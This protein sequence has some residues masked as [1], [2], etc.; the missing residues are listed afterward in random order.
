VHAGHADQGGLAGLVELVQVRLMLE[1]VGVQTLLGDLHVGLHVVGEHLD[2]KGH[3][4]F[5][6]GR[7]DEFENFRVGHGGG[8]HVQRLGGLGGKRR[9][10]GEGN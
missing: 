1:E 4:L 6:Q 8:R 9:D 3:A 7:F 10:G 2:V 5:G